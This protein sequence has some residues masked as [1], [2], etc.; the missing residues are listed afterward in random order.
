VNIGR[1]ISGTVAEVS[2]RVGEVTDSMNRDRGKILEVV[3]AAA[4][5]TPILIRHGLQRTPRYW[6]VLSKDATGDLWRDPADV[7]DSETIRFR[8]GAAATFTVRVW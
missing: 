4:P 3:G 2:R 8:S 5:G 7:W 1:A 6:T